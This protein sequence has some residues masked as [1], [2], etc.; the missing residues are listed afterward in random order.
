[1]DTVEVELWL[2]MAKIVQCWDWV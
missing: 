2:G 1:M